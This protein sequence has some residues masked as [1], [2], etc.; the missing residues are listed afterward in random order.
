MSVYDQWLPKN[1][2]IPNGPK[3]QQVVATGELWQIFT[4]SNGSVLVVN[5]ALFKEWERSALIVHVPFCS[6]GFGTLKRF[7]LETSDLYKLKSIDT[8]HEIWGYDECL[9]LAR[10]LCASRKLDPVNS[11][12]D[13][14]FVEKYGR[15]LPTFSSSAHMDDEL[16]F[17]RVLSN[18][19]NISIFSKQRLMELA[20]W[21]NIEQ[22]DELILE[23]GIKEKIESKKI[24]RETSNSLYNKF[25]LPGRKSLEAFFNEYII[26]VINNKDKYEEMGIDF[27]S[28]TILYG[29]P[30]T[31]KTYAVECLGEF[32]G[33]PIYYIDSNSIAS[34]YIHESGKK[35]AGVFTEAEKHSPSLVV[36]DEMEAYFASRTDCESATYHLEELSELLRK[37]ATATKN[38]ILVFG[39]TNMHSMLDAAALRHGRFDNQLEVL[40]P[41]IE[42]SKD[43]LAHIL[44]KLPVGED[45]DFEQIIQSLKGKPISDF[46]YFIKEA[47]RK[48]V[49]E[50]KRKIDQDCIN[51]ALN[52]LAP[53]NI[54]AKRV[55]F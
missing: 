12:Q 7:Y 29:P 5:E 43:L 16:V 51:F 45:I 3:L 55:G 26:D 27:P 48:A 25:L 39:M 24:T 18:G 36:I 30:G 52:K 32:L 34:P 19:V 35:I 53:S 23:S 1:F 38:H 37:I 50:N 14:I 46:S 6:F 20:P 54:T 4:C 41:T 22:I 17:G 8:E 28:P 11:F 9:V 31:G 49:R 15:L 47:S 13:S 33:W 42:E 10:S 44:K 2:Q 40:P 21:Y